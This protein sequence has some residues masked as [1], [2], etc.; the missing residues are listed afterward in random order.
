LSESARELL[1][2]TPL[3]ARRGPYGLCAWPVPQASAVA[4]GALR[5]RAGLWWLIVDDREVTALL[6]ESALGELPPP[7]Q[8]EK[9][10]SV[11]T[12]DLAMGWEVTGV[13]AAVSDAL[14]RAGIPLG[15][16]AAYSRDHL[17]VP[18][19]RLEQALEVLSGLCAGVRV[20]D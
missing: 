11:I 10:W 4:S 13:I 2:R 9:G 12:L 7:R 6:A 14:A 1:R 20:L 3:V 19:M 15:A 17:L 18:S 16:V 5:A 8:C